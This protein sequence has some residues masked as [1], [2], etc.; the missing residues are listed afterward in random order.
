MQRNLWRAFLLAM[1]VILVGDDP[2]SHAYTNPNT[3][4]TLDFGLTT[5]LAVRNLVW[6]DLHDDGVFDPGDGEQGVGGVQV[7]LVQ[8]GTNTV[9]LTTETGSDGIY[10]FG[11]G[12]A[13]G[14]W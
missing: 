3:D 8:A 11:V 7:E 4:F 10:T 1:A 12:T 9:V 13:A 14:S 5:G 2:N 6:Q